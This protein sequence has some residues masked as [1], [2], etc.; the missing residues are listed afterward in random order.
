MDIIGI[1]TEKLGVPLM[2]KIMERGKMVSVLPTLDE[3][4]NYVQEQ[5]VELPPR[6][7]SIKKHGSYRVDKSN[8]LKLLMQSC[9]DKH[10]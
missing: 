2:K 4:R 9:R 7:L 8:S 1:E 5:L 3:T 10:K 6:L